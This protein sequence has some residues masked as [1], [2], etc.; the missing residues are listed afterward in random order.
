[1][2]KYEEAFERA[3]AYYDS[4]D[5]TCDRKLLELVFPELKEKPM[6]AIVKEDFTKGD[7]LYEISLAYLN[8]NQVGEIEN[9]VE[10]WN[11]TNVKRSP[12]FKTGQWVISND[13]DDICQIIY[14][15]DSVYTTMDIYG[16]E[17]DK[18]YNTLKY[19]YHPWTINDA[20]EGDILYTPNGNDEYYI[21]IFKEIRDDNYLSA[22]AGL[23]QYNDGGESLELEDELYK[24][25]KVDEIYY[26]ATH[27]QKERLLRKLSKENITWNDKEKKLEEKRS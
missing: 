9:I 23:Y 3:R 11:G 27:E 19:D 16:N 4:T 14:Y 1:M 20:R 2:E 18:M 25:G 15:T 13:G 21:F 17:S 7:G 26:P 6:A 8:N 5:D 22:Y 10:K 12:I 24:L